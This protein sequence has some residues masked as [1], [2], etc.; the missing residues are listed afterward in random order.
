MG[1]EQSKKVPFH[2]ILAVGSTKDEAVNRYRLLALGKGVAAFSDQAKNVSFVTSSDNSLLELFNPSTGDLDLEADT[3]LASSLVFE[4]KAGDVEATHYICE[5][6]CGTHLVYDS[7]DLVK[8][9]PVCTSAVVEASAEAD[10]AEA[11]E[12]DDGADLNL[13]DDEDD[14]SESSDE[15]DE[16]DGEDE[17]ES[18][19]DGED[20]DDME[21]QAS[22]ED[23]MD[24]ED[25]DMDEDDGE[26]SNDEDDGEDADVDDGAPLVIAAA[27]FDEAK[28]LFQK[29]ATAK[30]AGGIAT[31]GDATAEVEYKVCAS[32]ACGA[33]VLASADAVVTDCPSCHSELKEP[34]ADPASLSDDSMKADDDLSIIDEE[35]EEEDGD[36]EEVETSESSTQVPVQTPVDPA[37]L[38]DVDALA[39][40]DDSGEDAHKALDLS[41]SSSIG[42]KPMWTAYF[43]GK[44]V[45]T[46]TAENA[47]K[48]ADIFTE[49][50]FG[51]AVIASARHVGVRNILRDMGF[52]GIQNRVAIAPIVKAEVG[53]EIAVAR[54]ELDRDRKEYSERLLAAMAT[55]AIGINRGFFADAK[56]P[57][58]EKLW[59]ALSA[60]GIKNPE[61]L[62]HNAFRASSDS[63]HSTL[64]A[65]AT[66]IIAKPLEVQE[67]LAKA[68]IGTNYLVSESSSAEFGAGDSEVE[69]RVGQ[70][71]TVT[72]ASSAPAADVRNGEALAGASTKI[73]S[74]VSSLGR[75]R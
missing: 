16:D 42:G 9:C 23:D 67:S 38:M 6:G 3:S 40:I 21:V 68:V 47:G 14:E 24:S 74:V 45:A 56:N 70:I 75:R 19:D 32:A 72:A 71:G 13:D 73:A 53:K 65:K 64:F 60:A 59:D 43:E 15:M 30:L 44:P 28:T 26:D 12:E 35:E 58:K 34:A 37:S 33:H 18:E 48:N 1:K 29:H 25:D 36:D 20:E 7:E 39:Q 49:G 22:V 55:A 17:D 27:T 54:S 50:S 57:L 62:I 46:A 31:A 66:E 4:A 11:D 69:N 10:D 5:S 51:H 41:Y 63:Y 8:F 52:R 2:G 61:A